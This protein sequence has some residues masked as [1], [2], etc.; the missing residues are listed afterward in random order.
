MPCPPERVAYLQQRAQDRTCTAAELCEL[1]YHDNEDSIA[2]GNL[3]VP[4]YIND[5]ELPQMW[6]ALDW[7]PKHGLPTTHDFSTLRKISLFYVYVPNVGAPVR[8][9]E[10]LSRKGKEV[11]EYIEAKG[12][13][14]VNPN[15]TPQER[16][17][18]KNRETQKRYRERLRSNADPRIEEARLAYQDAHELYIRLCRDRRSIEQEYRRQIAEADAN[19]KKLR[20]AFDSLTK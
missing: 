16:A 9:M 7:W 18:R 12:G 4:D 11:A 8:A 20:Q 13:S 3:V 6:A 14:V 5:A 2:M 10:I 19:R 15:E 17:A 1:F